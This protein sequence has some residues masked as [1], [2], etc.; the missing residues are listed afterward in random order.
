MEAYTLPIIDKVPSTFLE[1][2]QSSENGR[3]KGAVEEEM[4]SLQKN[5][6]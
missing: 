3:W 1:A 4:Q 5:K 2:I 6:T